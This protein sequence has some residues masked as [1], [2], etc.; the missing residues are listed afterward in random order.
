[1][2]VEAAYHEFYTQ[3]TPSFQGMGLPKEE[4]KIFTQEL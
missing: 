3:I 2:N 4:Y 1:M